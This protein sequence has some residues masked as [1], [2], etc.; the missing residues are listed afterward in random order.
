MTADLSYATT[1]A[2]LEYRRG[3]ALDVVIC[4]LAILTSHCPTI[5]LPTE[6]G[7]G[8]AILL[9]EMPGRILLTLT[10]HISYVC[11]NSVLI[12]KSPKIL[13]WYSCV[14]RPVKNGGQKTVYGYTLFRFS[15]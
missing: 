13:R 8:L 6:R 15:K 14:L 2:L 1:G 10:A 7:G 12:Y 5:L 11:K 9:P 4:Y 3:M